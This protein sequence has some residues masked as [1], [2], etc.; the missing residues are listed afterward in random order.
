[1][2]NEIHKPNWLFRGLMLLSVGLH[3]IVLIH[4]TT[5]YQ[6][7]LVSRIELTLQSIKSRPQPKAVVPPA[8]FELP[9]QN[10]DRQPPP[11]NVGRNSAITAPHYLPPKPVMAKRLQKLPS[12]PQI[13]DISD[14][15]ATVWEDTPVAMQQAAVAPAPSPIKQDTGLAEIQYIDRI[16]QKIDDAKEYPQRARRRNL[17]GVVKVLFTIGGRG[18]LVSISV[19]SSSGSRI[20]DRSAV[21]AVQKAA[22]FDPPPNK[23][24][25]IELPIKYQLTRS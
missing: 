8:R 14:P 3:L 22:P 11:F 16:K 13:T 17:E 12:S 2:H 23:T 9:M 24:V 21:K 15:V 10:F 20:L 5:I 4:V 1:M 19:S 25:T 18:E 7:N 6:P